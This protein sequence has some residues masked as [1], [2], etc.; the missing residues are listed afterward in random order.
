MSPNMGRVS[1]IIPTL[2]SEKTLSICLE[3]IRAQNINQDY[4]EILVIDGGSTDRTLELAT[5]Y[6]CA[7][8]PNPRIQQEFAKHIGLQKASGEI[9][10]FIDSDEVLENRDAIKNRVEIL[11]EH[12]EIKIVLSGG[13]KKPKGAS[14]INDY[15]NIF[16]DPF[17][18]FMYGIS[19][20]AGILQNSWQ[21]H[22]KNVHKEKGFLEFSF[23]KQDY[24]PLVDMCAGNTLNLRYFRETFANEI[25]NPLVVPK[26]F[27]MII[28]HTKKV[29]VLKN[30]AIIHY[31][32]D[33]LK[34]FV[35][36]LKWRVQ[37][38]IRF[39][40]MPGTG[41]SNREDYEP[42]WFYIKKIL[43]LP[44]ALTF[45]IPLLQAIYLAIKYKRKVLLLHPILNFYVG[46]QIV[47]QYILKLLNAPIKLKAYGKNTNLP[48]LKI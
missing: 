7:I 13:Y 24:K 48:N 26:I 43:Y 4:L 3:A 35:A 18:Y 41:F 2:N 47:W 39:K 5:K 6:G 42:S 44:Y 46:V 30:D 28:Q 27:Y 17:A 23:E 10:I 1:I 15:I 40:D 20:E 12:P 8:L 32:A 37:V 33:N 22:F 38:N 36:K 31:S 25:K 21:H 19:S 34:K 45:V 14:E 29:A 11:E 9:A 16:A